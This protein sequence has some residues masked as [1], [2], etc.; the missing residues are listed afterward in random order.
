MGHWYTK[1]G[2]A[3]HFVVGKNGKTRDTTLRDARKLN[4][5]PS[6]TEIL[7]IAAKPALTK[8]L[9]DQAFLSALTLP[10]IEGESLDDFKS[11]AESDS[12]KEAIESAN[13]GTEIHSAIESK[14]LGNNVDK[15]K[16]HAENVYNKIIEF[17]GVTTGWQAET[18]FSANGYGGMIDLHTK[19]IVID[20][21]TKSFNDVR[22][23]MAYDE[24][25]MQ[26][27][28]YAHGIGMPNARKI[29]VFISR[30]NPDLIQIH[31]WEEDMYDRF[32]C[33]LKYWQLTKKY[34][35][36]H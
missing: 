1:E 10:K 26:L 21:K 13:V 32:E 7:N 34:N 35:P 22:K 11:R 19:G 33:L 14:F 2:E 30:E 27:S 25:C 12:K 15:Y 8:W 29:N 18:T 20:Y 5:V 6:V 3:C 17:T 36:Q 16:D 9:V 23:K 4:L 28:A 31:E 24:H